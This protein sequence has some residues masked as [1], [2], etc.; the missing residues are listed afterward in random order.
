LLVFITILVV[1]A[2]VLANL[3]ISF[4]GSGGS[5]ACTFFINAGQSA[6]LSSLC[7]VGYFVFDIV[8]PKRIEHASKNIQRK[9][10]PSKTGKLEGDL[11][12]FVKNYNQI[13]ALLAEWADYPR[14]AYAVSVKRQP[15]RP[16]NARL[17]EILV[18]NKQ[19]DEP[20][21]KQLR[22]LVTLR[23]SIIHGAD[24]VVSQDIVALSASVLQDLRAALES[25]S[26]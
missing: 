1:L 26:D 18:R 19:I 5:R 17:A 20:L 24:P 2:I 4:E 8:S 3:A 13:E 25:R 7:A 6:F 12:E 9:I 21:Y 10:D 16:S 15:Q 22:N 11:R 23:N 14:I